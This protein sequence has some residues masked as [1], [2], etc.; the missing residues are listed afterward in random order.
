MEPGADRHA[1]PAAPEAT[2]RAFD[3]GAEIPEPA[4]DSPPG[5]LEPHEIRRVGAAVEALDPPARERWSRMR[6]KARP[7]ALAQSASSMTA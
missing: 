6:R 4:A 2:Q 1:L 7:R 3:T 5:R